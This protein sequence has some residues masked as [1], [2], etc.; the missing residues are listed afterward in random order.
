M[1]VLLCGGTGTF[2][3]L[4]HPLIHFIDSD[5]CSLVFLNGAGMVCEE[6]TLN[7]LLLHRRQSRYR[8]VLIGKKPLRHDVLLELVEQV[9][10]GLDH[11]LD[12]FRCFNVVGGLAYVIDMNGQS[13]GGVLGRVFQ[14]ALPHI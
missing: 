13:D 1:F 8:L 10:G 3:D 11:V 7:E 5:S 9:V 14:N 2:I 12:D 4:H 6:A